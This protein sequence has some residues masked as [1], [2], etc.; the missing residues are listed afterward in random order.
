MNPRKHDILASRLLVA[1]L[2]LALGEKAYFIAQTMRYQDDGLF[3]P[4]IRSTGQSWVFWLLEA[5][6]Q[7][8]LYRAIR[9][10]ERWAKAIVLLASLFYVYAG[11]QLSYG[12]VANV[13]FRHP[14]SW[15]LQALLRDLLTL[16][17]LALMFTKPRAAAA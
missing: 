14:D 8:I 3:P 17:A 10:G 15:A 7:V 5:L 9:R 12:Y 13:N 1:A 11:T 4:P 2:L 16:A 6:A